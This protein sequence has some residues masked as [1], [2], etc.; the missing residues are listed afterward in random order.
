MTGKNTRLFSAI[1]LALPL[2]CTAQESKI[3][4]A[5]A[6]EPIAYSMRS[7]MIA[8]TV[9]F[10]PVSLFV[11]KGRN[12]GLGD[13][14]TSIMYRQKPEFS[15]KLHTAFRASLEENGIALGD[16][17]R[18]KT[19]PTDPYTYSTKS[20]AS[21]GAP[22]VYTYFESIGV[23]SHHN[24]SY[25]QPAVYAAYCYIAEASQKDCDYADRAVFGDNYE[26]SEMTIAATPGD[27]WADADDV[28]L[29]A[30]EL[31]ASIDDAI[32]KL[33]AMMAKSLASELQNRAAKQ[34]AKANE[35]QK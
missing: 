13:R 23:R 1:A 15:A 7:D 6:P 34:I 11:A 8:A 19:D 25:Y 18:A 3:S 27:R 16:G 24:R 28:Y 9:L 2:V 30:D 5:Y 12:S 32:P 31:K 14:L 35:A 22:V 20:I 17:R 21:A 29:R 4:T 10:A 33:A 26:D